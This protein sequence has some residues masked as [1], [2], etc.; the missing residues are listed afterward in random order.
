MPCVVEVEF[1]HIKL[2]IVNIMAVVLCF[3]DDSLVYLEELGETTGTFRAD[4]RVANGSG[5]DREE[6]AD[7]TVIV[8]ISDKM[9]HSDSVQ[10]S[11]CEE[12]FCNLLAVTILNPV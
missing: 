8:T 1:M 9:N 5:I 7:F 2:I 11:S 4:L 10:V 12:S 3:S 6:M